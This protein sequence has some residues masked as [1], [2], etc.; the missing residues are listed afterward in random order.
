M[1]LT[2]TKERKESAVKVIARQLNLSVSTVYAILNDRKTCFAGKETKEKVKELAQKIGYKPNF[3]ARSLKHGK[4]GTIGLIV[5]RIDDHTTLTR[6][7][8]LTKQAEEKGYHI[9]VGCS[10]GSTVREE[11][12]FEEFCCRQVEGIIV[13]PARHETENK[14]LKSLIENNFPVVSY[15]EIPGV[16]V[17][18]VSTDY[19]MGGY[20]A[21][22]CLV[23]NGYR[24]IGFLSPVINTISIKRRFEGF[25][26]ALE[27]NGVEFSEERW[28]TFAKEDFEGIQASCQLMLD[29]DIDAVFCTNDRIALIF[30]RVAMD[31]GKKIPQELGV[32][33][34]DDI[35]YG[36][37]FPVTLT[38]ISQPL[39]QASK[40]IFALLFEKINDGHIEKHKVFLKPELIERES[41]KRR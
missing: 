3:I 31:R 2:G 18:F 25:K 13:V 28:V 23:K 21:G 30:M 1:N 27:D 14:F 35:E 34:F 8:I 12:L 33:G 19:F 11:E 24:K 22:Q 15:T 4:T 7:D 39:E 10:Y 20:L 29:K 17:D 36:R 5:S 41:T 38:T 26:R 9:F 16:D 6:L 32:I 37:L 40:E